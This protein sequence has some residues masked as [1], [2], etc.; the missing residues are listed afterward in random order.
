MD[1]TF[2]L[3]QLVPSKQMNRFH[4]G[5]REILYLRV[6][7]SY[8][9]EYCPWK[10]FGDPS[11]NEI[12]QFIQDHR[13]LPPFLEF[14]LNLEKEKDTIQCSS[15]LNHFLATPDSDIAKAPVVKIKTPNSLF[16]LNQQIDHCKS[17]RL[18]FNNY[19]NHD[20]LLVWANSLT[21]TQIN[22]IQYIEDPSGNMAVNRQLLSLGL[23]LAADRNDY[24]NSIYTFDIYKPNIDGIPLNKN[25]IFSSYMGGDLGRYHAYLALMKYGD[26]RTYHG[27][28]TPSLYQNQLQLFNVRDCHAE[29]N[30]NAL[31]Q[32]YS[33]LSE[34]KWQTL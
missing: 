33:Q 34:K 7:N 15:F 29:L 1:I 23:M 12:L 26:L 25:V 9:I 30:I 4:S 24:D 32:V 5:L 20:E 10:E 17:V 2:C 11:I 31:E 21:Q 28:D 22:K 6:Q 13:T 16:Q 8:Y 14:L 27:L 19:E 18:D 3:D